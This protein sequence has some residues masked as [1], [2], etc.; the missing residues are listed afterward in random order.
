MIP[1]RVLKADERLKPSQIDVL[2]LLR[3]KVNAVSNH[4]ALMRTCNL[5]NSRVQ[6]NLPVSSDEGDN[7]S[8]MW[9][10]EQSANS[11]PPTSSLTDATP[12]LIAL[13][14]TIT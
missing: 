14:V 10:Y 7:C 5:A 4:E 11:H 3:T 13:P 6:N 9:I 2:H 1:G 8:K 12:Q